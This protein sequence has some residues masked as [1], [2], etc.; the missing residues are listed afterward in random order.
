MGGKITSY[1]SS[2]TDKAKSTFI[3]R[4]PALEYNLSNQ[5]T[6]LGL[7]EE[8]HFSKLPDLQKIKTY[9][10]PASPNLTRVSGATFSIPKLG[11]K[12][13]RPQ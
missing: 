5:P 7:V 9:T 13:A 2:S 3:F 4:T 6:I 11:G 12:P 1:L 8:T 10:N